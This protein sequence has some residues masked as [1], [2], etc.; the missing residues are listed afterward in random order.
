MT[1]GLHPLRG[2]V[3]RLAHALARAGERLRTRARGRALP[4]PGEGDPGFNEGRFRADL[5]VLGAAIKSGE[6]RW[7]RWALA[8]ALGGVQGRRDPL[9]LVDSAKPPEG[10][11]LY[12]PWQIVRSFVANPHKR[13]YP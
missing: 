12:R 1:P 2:A 13:Y 10:D 4:P 5:S 9:G 3:R 7:C 8:R 11:P 6:D